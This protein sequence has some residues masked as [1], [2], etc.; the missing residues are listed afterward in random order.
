MYIYIRVFLSILHDRIKVIMILLNFP[1]IN[2]E[3]ML[4]SIFSTFTINI[5]LDFFRVLV[6]IKT[7]LSFLIKLRQ[8]YLPHINF[9]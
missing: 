2:L 5:L 8:F 6:C 3:N 7:N 4:L 9:K 1:F